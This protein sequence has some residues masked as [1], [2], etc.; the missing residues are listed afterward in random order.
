ME[1]TSVFLAAWQ[2][3]D[4]IIYAIS[5]GELAREENLVRFHL[6]GVESGDILEAEVVQLQIFDWF[7]FTSAHG[8]DLV[9]EDNSL[10]DGVP[11]DCEVGWFV[12]KDVVD[13]AIFEL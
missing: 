2:E 1:Y 9:E 5:L 8:A 11:I 4:L 6:D 13:F 10:Q 3:L 12:S 7:E